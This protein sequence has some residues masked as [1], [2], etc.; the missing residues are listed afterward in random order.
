MLTLDGVVVVYNPDES[1]E[2]N[3]LTY[4]EYV[5]TLYLVDNSEDKNELFRQRL[6]KYK[7]VSFI[8]SDGN[9]GIAW[10]L[11]MGAAAAISSGADWLLTMDQDSAFQSGSLGCLLDYVEEEALDR[12]G[13]G[14]VSPFHKTKDGV[15]A[16]SEGL[17]EVDGV[18]TS[19]NVLSL[20]ACQRVGAFREDYFI[21]YVDHEYC[22][23]LKKNG[24]KIGVYRAAILEHSLGDIG[25]K[26]IFGRKFFFTNHNAQRRYYITRNRLDV[27]RRYFTVAPSFCLKDLKGFVVEW[28]KILFFETKKAEKS[29]Y[30]ARGIADSLTCNFGKLRE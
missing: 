26:A 3:I 9:Q 13:F 27:V 2:R 4:L 28:F 7:N 12:V 8:D 19:G 6:E 15:E 23:R 16:A 20:S 1:V 24:Y 10:A 21:D 30:I 11:N 5:R 17:L 22:L 29:K 14:I 18:M 25:C